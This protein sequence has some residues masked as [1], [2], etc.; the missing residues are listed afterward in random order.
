MAKNVVINEVTYN[1]VPYVNIPQSGGGT[2]SFYDTS[3]A[4]ASQSDILS[5]AT[6][7]IDGGKKTGSMVNN[8]STSGTISSKSGTV[9]VP[10][11]YT[12]GG[13]ISIDATEVAKIIASNIKNG[14]TILGQAGGANILDTT[15][16]SSAAGAAQILSG[17]KAYANGALVTG[18]ATVPSVSQDAS[19]KVLTIS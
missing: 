19:T 11:G 15:V 13:T 2:A 4:T 12:S 9:V 6:A 1:A 17:Y 8:G 3:D 10:Q 14:V 7:Y 16:S 5:G 18:E